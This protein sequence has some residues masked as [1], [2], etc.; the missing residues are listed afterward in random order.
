MHKMRFTATSLKILLLLSTG[1]LLFWGQSATM[2][3]SG[4]GVFPASIDQVFQS[5]DSYP[6]EWWYVTGRLKIQG[7]RRRDGFEGTFF[8]FL[9]SYRHP[10]GLPRSSW[11]PREIFSFHGAYSRIDAGSFRSTEY[12][13]RSFRKAVWLRNDPLDIRVGSA[14][15]RVHKEP[16]NPGS[17][18]L[19]LVEQ[20]KD[21]LLELTLRGS[22]PPLM[23]GPGGKLVTGKGENDWAWY[24]SYPDLSVSGREGRIQ[25]DGN[26]VWKKVTGVAWFDHEWTRTMLGKGQTGWIWLGGRLDS[27]KKAL[28]AFQMHGDKGP[29]FFRGGTLGVRTTKGFR[30]VWLSPGDVIVRILSFWKSPLTGICYPDRL[31]IGDRLLNKRWRI[32]PALDGQELSGHPDYWEGAVDLQD[33]T[34]GQKKGD[35]YL[36]LTGFLRADQ[37]CPNPS[38]LLPATIPPTGPMSGHYRK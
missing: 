8:R 7:H 4:T 1:I 37:G 16:G 2:A 3:F 10:S 36:E 11:E 29:D 31:E 13:A 23:E 35:G 9:T 26:V 5:H 27:G 20:V 38:G 30:T 24:L 17:F 32:V 25:P 12:L 15:L 21:R 14:R 19:E 18:D 33:P 6:I 22:G 28:M 34:T